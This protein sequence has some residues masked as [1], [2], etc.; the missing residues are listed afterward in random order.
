MT[1]DEPGLPGS[2]M[3]FA[4]VP[5]A[6]NEIANDIDNLDINGTCNLSRH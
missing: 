4:A 5:D 6:A 2:D 1:L 3:N